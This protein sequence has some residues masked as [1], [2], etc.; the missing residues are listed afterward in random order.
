[1]SREKEDKQKHC[2]IQILIDFKTV[3]E[4]G[5]KLVCHQCL[6]TLFILKVLFDIDE[7]VLCCLA[8]S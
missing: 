6:L 7:D 5:W 4:L 2:I 1:M 8:I 3:G